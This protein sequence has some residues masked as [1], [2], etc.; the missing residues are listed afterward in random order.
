MNKQHFI[1]IAGGEL[2]DALDAEKAERV[3]QGEALPTLQ[4][5]QARRGILGAQLVQSMFGWSVRYD[6][7]LQGWGILAGIR[8]GTLDGSFYDAVRWAEDWVAQDP[9][10]RYAWASR[11]EVE[12]AGIVPVGEEA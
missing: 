6:S 2:S 12:R 9:E 1:I 8:Q 7:G 5:A 11:R 10:R 4:E 3:K